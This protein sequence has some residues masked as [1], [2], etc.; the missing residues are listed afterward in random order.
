MNWRWLFGVWDLECYVSDSNMLTAYSW[1]ESEW[2]YS[3]AN[4]LVSRYLNFIEA[5]LSWPNFPEWMAKRIRFECWWNHLNVTNSKDIQMNN[6]VLILN[7]K[8]SGWP[9][10]IIIAAISLAISYVLFQLGIYLFFLP[11]I[12]FVPFA[13]F[14]KYFENRQQQSYICPTCGLASSGN[15]CPQCGSRL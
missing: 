11:I 2:C 10:T 1:A 8:W 15:Y 14:F 12:F 6:L 5:N 4:S 13:R 9:L 7:M 3:V